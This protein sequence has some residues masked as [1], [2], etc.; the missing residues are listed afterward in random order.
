MKKRILF[1]CKYNRFRSRVAA[2]YFRKINKNKKFEV[3]SA[4]LIKGEPINPVS[5]KIA[6]G[7]GLNIHGKT[8]GLSSELL[9]KQDLVVIVADDVPPS[10]LK[11]H[12]RK[13][14]VLKVKD[15]KVINA[16]ILKQIIKE[17]IKKVDDLNKKLK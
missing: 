10:V 5:E 13:I 4:G 12:C 17:I 15:T 6:R 9:K 7:F 2:E 11:D 1:V 16:R 14:I 8:R 3:S